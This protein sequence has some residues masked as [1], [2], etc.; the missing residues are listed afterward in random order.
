MCMGNVFAQSG[1]TFKVEE[2]KRPTNLLP[3]SPYQDVLQNLINADQQSMRLRND[4]GSASGF[5]IVAK[6][7]IP[8]PLV[9][10]G[11][12]SFYLGMYF[13]YA[14]HRPFT[15]SPD[16]IWLLIAQ[17][18][19]HHVN[20]NAEE[21]RKLFVDFD[22]QTTLTVKN[23]RIQLGDPNSPWAEAFDDFSKQIAGHTGKELTA[24]M[25]ADFSTTTSISRVAS[26]ITLMN[27]VK[28]FFEFE[29]MTSACGIPEVTL[30]G[31][32]QDWERVLAK[33]EALR[34]YKLD[35]WIDELKSVLKQ[36]IKASNGKIDKSFW[37]RMYKLHTS[38]NCGGPST[39]DGWVIKFYPYNKNNKRNNLKKWQGAG[40]YL[41]DE[42]LK[43]DLKYIADDGAGHTVDTPLEI[44]AGFVGLEQ[45]NTTF[46]LKPA[47]GWMIR[48][49]DDNKQL[50]AK[51]EEQVGSGHI[52]MKISSVPPELLN[53]GPIQSLILRFT[54]GIQIP[55]AL[56]KVKIGELSLRGTI[57]AE[58][59][60]R[61]IKLFPNTALFINGE[62]I[63]TTTNQGV[64]GGK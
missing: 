8:Q 36:F 25:T 1:I 34:K 16:M 52:S 28:S 27:A 13:A 59:T 7:D 17:G 42:I 40:D 47:I 56:A 14:E 5:N 54:N 53:I 50:I 41:P 29:L 10:Y 6:S 44:W 12:S 60:K 33:T 4:R 63:P 30:E 15:L 43:V 38:K 48:K 39:V 58:E 49:K 21:L 23:D 64:K 20:A 11:Y 19:A 24:A 31:T 3:V 62:Q 18:F 46:A 35:W 45:N 26:Q 37:Q 32:P 9:A 51:L 57:T 55:D 61:I 2:L 22:G